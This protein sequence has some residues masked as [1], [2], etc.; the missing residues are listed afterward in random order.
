MVRYPEHQR[1][2]HRQVSAFRNSVTPDGAPGPTGAGGFKA[3]AG[4][5]HL[6]VSLACPWAHRTLIFRK[7]E[8]LEPMIA[9]SV[10]HWLMEENGWTFAEA[11]GVVPDPIQNASFLHEISHERSRLH[12]TCHRA[13]ALGQ[14][15]EYDCEQRILKIFRMFNSALTHVV[16]TRRLLPGG[17]GREIDGWNTRIYDTVNNGVYSGFATSQEAYEEASS[18][19][20][21]HW[22]CS[23][24]IWAGIGT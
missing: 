14:G 18:G 5:Y 9:L 3:E 2:L 16:R 10:V 21:R 8:R 11:P 20:S 4:R 1:T 13:G 6:Y 7:L 12:G 23:T 19:C 22:I 24:S 17:A 15:D